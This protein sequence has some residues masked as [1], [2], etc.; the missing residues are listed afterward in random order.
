MD[1]GLPAIGKLLQLHV[2]AACSLAYDVATQ[3]L[4]LPLLQGP[5][6]VWGIEPWVGPPAEVAVAG[7]HE[8]VPVSLH[9]LQQLAPTGQV[10]A[11]VGSV[12]PAVAEPAAPTAPTDQP[13]AA[14]PAPVAAGR[15]KQLPSIAGVLQQWQPHRL[16]L[17]ISPAPGTATSASSAHKAQEQG[18]ALS[19]AA[20]LL[21]FTVM[22]LEQVVAGPQY[23][24]MGDRDKVVAAGGAADAAVLLMPEQEA[25]GWPLAVAAEKFH[26]TY[27]FRHTQYSHTIGPC[28]WRGCGS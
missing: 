14:A 11:E 24:G 20:S 12:Q 22:T 27:T 1:A 13:P 4:L 19:L 2:T 6:A 21:G 7:V 18:Q 10:D 3:L 15:A 23:E 8:L 16:L 17:L 9:M 25:G 5:H 28:G 26:S